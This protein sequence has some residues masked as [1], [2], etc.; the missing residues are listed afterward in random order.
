MKNELKH[1]IRLALTFYAICFLFRAE[2]YFIIRTDQS[3]IGEAFIHK[4][5]GIGLLA[6]ALHFLGYKWSGIGFRKDNAL[7][8]TCFGL[9]FGI[10]VFAVA[11]GFEMII[12]SLNGKNPSLEFYLTSYSVEGNNAMRS[13]AVFI[14]ICI[15]GNIVNVVMEEGVFRGLF[16]KI[17]ENKYS[18]IKV[19][20][21]SSL[22]FGFWHIISPLRNAYDGVQSPA[23]AFMMGLMLVGTSALAGAQYV[24]LF[25]MTGG[26][27]MPMAFHFV[28]N[29]SVN[30]L[31]VVTDSG[32]DELQT[33]RLTITGT[34]SFVIVLIMFLLS[35]K[36]KN[37]DAVQPQKSGLI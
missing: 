20:I 12:N 22:L 34:L 9:L 36:R 15:L 6:A 10:A 35:R 1:P 25:K 26:L 33:I 29:T 11:Y 32:A 30:L 5:I 13:G 28:N 18:F 14:L 3:I 21:F 2:E 31:H 37:R 16:V 23:G 27:W 7:K 24:M 4:L 8:E 17:A 19:C